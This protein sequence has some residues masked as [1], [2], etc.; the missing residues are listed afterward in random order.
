MVFPTPSKHTKEIVMNTGSE[1]TTAACPITSGSLEGVGSGD[2]DTEYRF[3][4][5][6]NVLASFPFTTREFA[7]LLVLRS[8]IEAGL[9]GADDH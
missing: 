6:P 4:R 3:G 9:C 8:R 2:H 5:R 7:R 1:L